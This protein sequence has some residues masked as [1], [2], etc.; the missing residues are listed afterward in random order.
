MKRKDIKMIFRS[1]LVFVSLIFSSDL[2]NHDYW[3]GEKYGIEDFFNDE[4]YISIYRVNYV[5]I[6]FKELSSDSIFFNTIAII[7]VAPRW[8]TNENT[9]CSVYLYSYQQWNPNRNPIVYFLEFPG[10]SD[11][12]KKG[13]TYLFYESLIRRNFCSLTPYMLIDAPIEWL[14][15]NVIL[16]K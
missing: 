3:I 14:K 1:V 12:P 16:N 9:K 8:R 7:E 15:E 11:V 5:K 2:N 6:I 10:E 4:K 13:E